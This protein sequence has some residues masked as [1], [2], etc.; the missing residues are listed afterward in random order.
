MSVER[1]GSAGVQS[2]VASKKE[3]IKRRVFDRLRSMLE[4]IRAYLLLIA[5]SGG[6]RTQSRDNAE[7]RERERDTDRQSQ[8]QAD[9]GQ[10]RKHT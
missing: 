7:Q 6:D 9:R 2:G 8:R 10:R 4:R 1:K 3:D 5:P